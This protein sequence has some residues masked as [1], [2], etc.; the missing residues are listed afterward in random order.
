MRN[1]DVT[2]RLRALYVE[3][4][5]ATCIEAADTIAALREYRDTVTLANARLHTQ[6]RD[7]ESRLMYALCE[8]ADR[9]ATHGDETDAKQER[10]DRSPPEAGP[11]GR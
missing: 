10:K 7:L 1:E 8:R 5:D 11:D 3:T 6:I 2:Q 9:F 4:G